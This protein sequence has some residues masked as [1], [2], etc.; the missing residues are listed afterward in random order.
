MSSWEF[1]LEQWLYVYMYVCMQRMTA[2]TR[3]SN[4]TVFSE[5]L[6]NVSVL[7][8][9]NYFPRLINRIFFGPF[10]VRMGLTQGKSPDDR[11]FPTKAFH[12]FPTRH[13]NSDVE[14]N[15][16]H[17]NRRDHRSEQVAT[18]QQFGFESR[19]IPPL[20]SLKRLVVLTGPSRKIPGQ[21]LNYV[22]TAASKCFHLI[23][24]QSH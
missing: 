7:N 21:Y 24:H 12:S 3:A 13:R 20:F 1:C 16:A 4:L 6:Y 15:N 23:G 10:S 11:E 14:F 19:L 18:S 22:M 2:L 17:L 8:P 9:E 5:V